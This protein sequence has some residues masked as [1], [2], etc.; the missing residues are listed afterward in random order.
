ML[1]VLLMPLL[2]FE[3][4]QGVWTMDAFTLTDV[5]TGNVVDG[6]PQV[7]GLATIG[8]VAML[9]LLVDIFMFKARVLQMRVI[10]YTIWLLIGFCVYLGWMT[11]EAHAL[12]D[13]PIRPSV[14]AG[15]PIISIIFSYLAV[16]AIGADEMLVRSLDRL[17]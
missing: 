3:S 13:A 1:P 10:S 5:A 4:A 8:A 6:M 7:W 15:F 2:N 12:L 17:R 11:Y 16:R 9:L 14:V